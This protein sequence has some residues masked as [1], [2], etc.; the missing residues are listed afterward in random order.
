MEGED[1]YFYSETQV[2]SGEYDYLE[3]FGNVPQLPDAS[4]RY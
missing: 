3:T 1:G 4:S 2:K